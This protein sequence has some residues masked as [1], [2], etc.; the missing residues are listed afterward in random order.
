[1]AKRL[2]LAMSFHGSSDE[3]RENLAF[4]I[5]VSSRMDDKLRAEIKKSY[6]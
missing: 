6:L 2:A 4:F 1:M 3:N 5:T